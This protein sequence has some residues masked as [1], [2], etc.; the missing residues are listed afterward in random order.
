MGLSTLLSKLEAAAEGE[1]PP[2]RFLLLFW[3]AGTI[4]YLFLPQGEGRG[5]TSSPILQPF[6]DAGLRNDMTVLYG[7]RDSRKAIDSGGSEGGVVLRTTCADIPGTRANGGE[8]D[9]AVAGGPSIDQILSKRVPELSARDVGPV[10]AIGD[11]R[12]DSQETSAQC[13]SYSYETR[14]VQSARTGEPLTEHVPL[15]PEKSPSRLYSQ[16]F[17]G[18]MPGDAGKDRELHNALQLRKSVLDY[19]LGEL[20]RLRALA[21]ASERV[22]IDAHAEAI[23]KI[24]VQ[25]SAQLE[26]PSRSCDLPPPPDVSLVARSGSSFDYS[27]PTAPDD[28]S[29]AL[30]EL[31][32]LHLGVIQAAFQCDVTR[33]ATFQWTTSVDHV[34]FKGLYPGEPETAYR[35]HPLSHRVS[36]VKVTSPPVRAEEQAVHQFL[37]NVQTWYNQRTAEALTAFKAARDIFGGSLL[38]HTI[39]PFVTDTANLSHA[40]SPLPALL[41]GGSALGM[42]GGQFANYAAS[43]RPFADVWLTV[44]QAYLRRADVNTALQDEVFVQQHGDSASPLPGLWVPT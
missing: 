5:Y 9:D 6:E 37:A 16:V 7:L 43:T 14:S 36:G 18:F 10:N 21:P 38:D 44:A 33:V 27:D 26:M 39:V 29:Q 25:L 12:V 23:R 32:R 3:P 17:S 42:Q 19:S 24:E 28:E 40:R 20:K 22:R 30:A 15:M 35:N 4:P 34:A 41:F 1:K 8:S 11:A 2:P 31:G 13:L